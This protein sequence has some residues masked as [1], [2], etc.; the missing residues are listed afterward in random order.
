[1]T[2]IIRVL[3]SL[4]YAS[5]CVMQDGP[6]DFAREAARM[7]LIYSQAHLIVAATRGSTGDAGL[8]QDRQVAQLIT[9]N[10]TH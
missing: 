3:L 8:F 1:M 7:A 4:K 2:T 5:L 6:A 9:R 10:D